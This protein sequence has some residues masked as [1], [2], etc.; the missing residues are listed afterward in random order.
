[1]L[2]RAPPPHE[3]KP[4]A[5]NFPSQVYS[6]S[7]DV[8]LFQPPK[9]YPEPP[10]DMWYEVPK[11]KPAPRTAK[12][13]SIFPWEDRQ[14][15]HPT[16][17]FAEDLLSPEP[18]SKPIPAVKLDTSA[19]QDS[20]AGESSRAAPATRVWRDD[21]PTTF[22]TTSNV[23]D[24]VAGIDTYVRSMS[25]HQKL[26][27]K[28]QVLH[29]NSNQAQ[30]PVDEGPGPQRGRRESLVLTDFPSAIERPSL[31]VTPAPQKK[32]F[33]GSERDTAGQLPQ[34]EGVPNQADWVSHHHMLPFIACCSPFSR[35]TNPFCK[36][37]RDTQLTHQSRIQIR[38]SKS[39]AGSLYRWT[40]T[41]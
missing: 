15:A 18:E 23:W 37:S 19:V 9:A 8:K 31:P 11:E 29:N 12:P 6:M 34:A 25:Q 1:M 39:C 20:A 27:G 40:P 17:V 36:F 28:L 10:K 7:G 30:S 16:R 5:Q 33:W 24:S 22:G 21:L 3:S 2:N 26:R 38:N 41:P 14:S 4:E 35:S 32:S 13:K